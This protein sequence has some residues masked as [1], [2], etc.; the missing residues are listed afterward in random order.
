MYEQQ[1]DLGPG[2]VVFMFLPLVHLLARVTQIVVLDVGG[3][4]T[5]WRGD[6]TAPLDDLRSVR[7]RH[8]PTV[9]RVLGKIRTATLSGADERGGLRAA[10]LC[11]TLATARRVRTSSRC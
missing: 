5:Y 3:T 8:L 9:P 11:R 2:R 1:I 4:V 7:A 10:A 6:R